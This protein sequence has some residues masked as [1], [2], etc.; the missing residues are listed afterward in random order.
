MIWLLN[1]IFRNQRLPGF[2]IHNIL[3]RNRRR[4]KIELRLSPGAKLKE[5]GLLVSRYPSHRLDRHVRGSVGNMN[6]FCLGGHPWWFAN[7]LLL[8]LVASVG[9]GSTEM[10]PPMDSAGVPSE[11]PLGESPS[12]S[13]VTFC[14]EPLLGE[15][16]VFLIDC[17]PSMTWGE[18]QRLC[19]HEVLTAIGAMQT[20]QKFCIVGWPEQLFSEI[21]LRASES[22]RALA[23]SWLDSIQCRGN[24]PGGALQ[25]ALEVLEGEEVG[26]QVLVIVS[27]QSLHSADNAAWQEQLVNYKERQG[28]R[29]ELFTFYLGGP[30]D[31]LRALAEAVG[32]QSF[33]PESY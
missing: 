2:S 14:G 10:N 1:S 32:G 20:H 8:A 25:R 11:T 19:Q 5:A 28:D 12:A 33:Q 9:C 17:S 30:G 22:N 27:D 18:N 23:A 31:S 6:I 7:L 4:S 15:T 13:S 16:F 29:F 26:R 21:P 24:H 3:P